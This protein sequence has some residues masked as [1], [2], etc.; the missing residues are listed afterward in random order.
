MII[1]GIGNGTIT[2]ED[3]TSIPIAIPCIGKPSTLLSYEANVATGDKEDLPVILGSDT[4]QQE[5]A[6]VILRLGKEMVVFPGRGGYVIHASPGTKV[7]PM[8]IMNTGH[9]SLEVDHYETVDGDEIDDAATTIDHRNHVDDDVADAPTKAEAPDFQTVRPTLPTQEEEHY[10]RM[11][12]N[13]D[14]M[15]LIA[16]EY[17]ETQLRNLPIIWTSTPGPERNAGVLMHT[18]PELTEEFDMTTQESVTRAEEVMWCTEVESKVPK[19]KRTTPWQWNRISKLFVYLLGATA[20]MYDMIKIWT[21]EINGELK[22][23]DQD[24]SEKTS[25]GHSDA[26]DVRRDAYS[27]MHNIKDVMTPSR[28][29]EAD[30]DFLFDLDY[31]NRTCKRSANEEVYHASKLS[32]ERQLELRKGDHRSLSCGQQSWLDVNFQNAHSVSKSGKICFDALGG[33]DKQFRKY[34]YDELLRATMAFSFLQRNEEEFQPM[35]PDVQ[36]LRGLNAVETTIQVRWSAVNTAS[37]PLDRSIRIEMQATYFNKC[38]GN[39]GNL[40]T[41]WHTEQLRLIPY[42]NVRFSSKD[43]RGNVNSEEETILCVKG[44]NHEGKMK[45]RMHASVVLSTQAFTCFPATFHKEYSLCCLTVSGRDDSP[46]LCVSQC[47]LLFLQL[48]TVYCAYLYLQNARP[49]ARLCRFIGSGIYVFSCSI[50]YKESV[51]TFA[52]LEGKGNCALIGDHATSPL[53]SLKEPS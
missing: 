17:K 8:S 43:V 25:H 6:I 49:D 14:D 42:H 35:G 15:R 16:E 13:S 32:S 51:Q 27:G 44:I 9:L 50:F 52:L 21:P 26:L 33:L 46:S 38:G 47:K 45:G 22:S 18:C 28:P 48:R 1:A 30:L 53:P 20:L 24:K 12:K 2:I 19:M 3:Q 29:I 36:P 11:I 34:Y 39:S 23:Q 4:M 41:M 5:D 10:K 40:F 37:R 7:H 31:R